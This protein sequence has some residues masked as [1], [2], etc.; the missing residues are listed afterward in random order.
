[1]ARAAT[2]GPDAGICSPALPW[3]V[4]PAEQRRGRQIAVGAALVFVAA[5]LLLSLFE[6]PPVDRFEAEKLPPRLAQL[7]AERR[8]PPKPEPVVEKPKEEPKPEVKEEPPPEAP[9]E[10]RATPTEQQI[11]EAREKASKSG[12]LAMKDQLAALRELS[13]AALSKQQTQVGAEGSEQRVERDLIGRQATSGSGGVATTAVAHGGGGA[14]AGRATTQVEVPATAGQSLAV[15]RA[16]ARAPRRSPEEI[17]LAFDANKSAIY[18]LY[19]RALRQNPLLEGRVVV[20]LTVAPSGEVTECSIVSSALEDP[21]LESKLVARIQLI[22]FG[23]RAGV[24]TWT[25]TYHI[26]FVPTG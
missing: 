24:E 20:K 25:G 1:V 23:A 4:V 13:T 19:R 11:R 17:K 22:N 16:K 10:E 7:L 9:K 6:P 12:L 5:A 8:E 2:L 14:L 21:D 3:A 18:G 26:D 15:V